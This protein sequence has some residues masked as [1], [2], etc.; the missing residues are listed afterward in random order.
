MFPVTHLGKSSLTFLE[1]L[2]AFSHLC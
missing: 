2:I 1:T